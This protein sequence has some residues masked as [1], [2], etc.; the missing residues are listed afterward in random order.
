MALDILA[1]RNFGGA[2]M[3]RRDFGR[4]ISGVAGLSLAAARAQESGPLAETA[5]GKVRGALRKA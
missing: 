5:S 4:M 1:S 2:S 3:N